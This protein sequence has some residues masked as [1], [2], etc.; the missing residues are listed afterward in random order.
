MA[1]SFDK[2]N[3]IITVPAPTTEITVQTLINEIRDWED[4]LVN[5]DVAKIAD[6]SGKEDLGGGLSVGITLKLLSWKLKFADRSGPDY[7]DCGVTGGNLV[8]VDGNNQPMNPIQ[9]AAYVTVTVV[10]AV[11]AA[12]IADV[13]EWT[14]AE[15][16][17]IISDMNLVESKVTKPMIIQ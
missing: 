12:L 7:V 15:K 9:P 13:A 3:K 10:K 1:L 2:I 17:G 11:S 6:A 5:I 14:Q 4:E 16:D 8:A